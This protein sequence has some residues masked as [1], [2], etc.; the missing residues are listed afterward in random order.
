MA[1]DHAPAP[2]PAALLAE[3]LVPPDARPPVVSMELLDLVTSADG[4]L[5]AIASTKRVIVLDEELKTRAGYEP[6]G[7]LAGLVRVDRAAL[8]VREYD[9]TNPDCPVIENRVSL[10]R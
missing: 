2:Y 10:I 3:D 9:V 7:V 6:D 4:D 8:I 5:L 1:H